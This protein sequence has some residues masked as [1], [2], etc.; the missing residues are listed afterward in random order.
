[1][2]TDE[3]A[4]SGSSM[5]GMA[6]RLNMLMTQY[7]KPI[8]WTAERLAQADKVYR[9]WLHIAAKAKH[10]GIPPDELLEAL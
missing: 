6:I 8:D 3:I 2:Q 1:M 5:G 9:K 4:I 7:R 10:P